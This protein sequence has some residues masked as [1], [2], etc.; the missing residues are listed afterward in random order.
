MLNSLRQ[1]AHGFFGKLLLGILV[2][3]FGIWGIGDIVRTGSIGSNS[4][5]T[6]GKAPISLQEYNH[7]LHERTERLQNKLGK[8]YS[9]SLARQLG[10]NVQVINELVNDSLIDQEAAAQGIVVGDDAIVK[11]ISS[12]PAFHNKDGNFDKEIYI[13]TLRNHGLAEQRYVEDLR[14]EKAEK[15]LVDAISTGVVVPY[16]LADAIYQSREEQRVASLYVISPAN[17]KQAPVPTEQEI[18]SYYDAH[19]KQFMTPEYRTVSYIDLKLADIQSK[20]TIPEEDIKHAYDDRIQDFHKPDRRDVEQMLFAKESDAA[21]VYNKLSHGAKFSDVIRKANLINKEKTS[22]GPV[23]KQDLPPE[24][25]DTIFAL[26]EG[27]ASKPFKSDFGW[28]VF[29]VNKILP[30]TTLPLAEV[31]DSIAKDLMASKASDFL[32]QYANK[33]EDDMAGGM[34]L[35]DVAKKNGLTVKTVN[36]VTREG[37]T[38]DAKTPAL[39]PYDNFLDVAFTSAEKDHSAVIQT[40]DGSYFVL[41]VDKVTPE[42]AQPMA[43]VLT[44]IT[45]TLKKEKTAAALKNL[46][47]DTAAKLHMGKKA[48]IALTPVSSGNI[49]RASTSTQDGKI[50]LPSDLVN[51]IFGAAVHGYTDAYPTQTGEYLIASL[52]K[53]IPAPE[54]ANPKLMEDISKELHDSLQNEILSAYLTYLRSKYPVSINQAIM[55][56]QGQGEEGSE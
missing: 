55:A 40:E 15:L 23:A 9:P 47:E 50:R 13:A 29:Y 7:L 16:E 30:E 6:V 27:E 19:S 48:D 49:K 10:I 33:I 8:A 2:L 35:E 11:D 14:R 46:A 1:S 34:S 28:H 53:I 31:H 24:E 26:K 12:N 3:S 41:R 36:Q 52:D 4:A 21:D 39:P 38:A 32:G 45:A 5:A 51:D 20:I 25:A 54:K 18:K 17:L 43:D 56:Q 22:L 37:K 42:H 44:Q